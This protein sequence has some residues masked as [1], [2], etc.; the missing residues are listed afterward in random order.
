MSGPKPASP[1]SV[2]RSDRRFLRLATQIPGEL[3]GRTTW[4]VEVVDL[5]LGG[6]LVRCPA[7]V[8]AGTILDLRFGLGAEAFAAKVRV[9]EV[10]VD[11]AAT[12]PE[13]SRYLVG[14]EYLR[15]AAS[16]QD[17]LRHF[18]ESES[19]RRRSAPASPA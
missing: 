8:D 2:K 18:L 9:K 14:L 16:D 5:S 3:K 11:G 12:S 15:L 4:A 10:S 7:R 19:R 1:E 17:L 6:C 13:S